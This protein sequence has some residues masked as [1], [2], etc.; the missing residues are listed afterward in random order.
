MGIFLGIRSWSFTTKKTLGALEQTYIDHG[1]YGLMSLQLELN[2]II[3][4]AL[5][6]LEL[7]N[8]YDRGY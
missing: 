6:H 4:D 7:Y 2:G 8:N 3:I 1:A 5:I